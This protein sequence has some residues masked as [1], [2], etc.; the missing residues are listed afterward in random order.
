MEHGR[1][2][3]GAST[4]TTIELEGRTLASFAG[5]SYL[6]LAHHPR[7][8]AALRAGIDEHGISAGASRATSGDSVAHVELEAHAARFLGC[9]AALLV[10]SGYLANL[11][12]AQGLAP[13]HDLALADARAHASSRDALAASGWEVAEYAHASASDAARVLREHRTAR[14][15]PSRGVAIFTDGVF[16]AS[17]NVAPLPELLALLPREGGTLVVD[18]GHASGVLGA[19]GRGTCEHFALADRRIVIT[20]TLSKA[21]G[22][23]GGLIAGARDVV[24]RIRVRSRAFVCSSPIPPALARAASAAIRELEEHPERLARLRASC[25]RLR[26]HFARLDLPAPE[27]DLPVFAFALRPAERMAR[28]QRALLE[29]GIFVPLIRYPDGFDDEHGYLRASVNA[30]HTIAD[31]D[32]LARELESALRS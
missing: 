18:D 23:A 5:C 30:E 1:F 24:E 7:V 29:R 19:R 14:T 20:T 10:P 22:C 25:A 31:V 8:I 13:D 6:G 21:F 4:A 17:K 11:V 15:T 12:T 16:P 9:D 3:I 2:E 26:E 32:R 28:V 27:L